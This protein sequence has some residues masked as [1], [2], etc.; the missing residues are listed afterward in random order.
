MR[1]ALTLVIAA[2]R[3]PQGRQEK[4]ERALAAAEE[5]RSA[6][7]VDEVE[8]RFAPLLASD[9]SLAE[10][11]TQ[12]LNKLV[13]DIRQA[14]AAWPSA[15]RRDDA[16]AA[17]EAALLEVQDIALQAAY[18]ALPDR[19]VDH[20]EQRDT[21]DSIVFWQEFGDE[22]AT[23]EQ[24]DQVLRWLAGSSRSA[25]MLVDPEEGVIYK[26]PSGKKRLGMAS[27]ALWGALAGL[28]PL[29]IL[30]G[31][32][33][34]LGIPEGDWPFADWG[35]LI[36]LYVCV[37]IGAGLH[38]LASMAKGIDFDGELAVT[39][40]SRRIDWLAIRWGSVLTLFLPPLITTVGLGMTGL[41]PDTFENFATAVLAGYSADSLA[42][43]FMRRLGSSSE[44]T[45]KAITKKPSKR[46]VGAEATGRRRSLQPQG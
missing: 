14:Q 6:L 1:D 16:A 22:L 8:A 36:G 32:G 9:R 38:F 41:R 21:G 2:A 34:W 44:K 35:D 23:E 19:L 15:K 33:S 5:A 30:S 25:G 4:L 45:A 27:A 11:V 28:I 24:G 29:T 40:S 39:Q 17:A 13:S 46:E 31:G 10:D 12:H 37:V 7:S 42:P 3:E 20:L 26:V 18:I 43:I